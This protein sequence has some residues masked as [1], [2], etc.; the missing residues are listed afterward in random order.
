MAG[1][2]QAA[3]LLE[4]RRHGEASF[5]CGFYR[6]DWRTQS[7]PFWVKHHWHEELEI[8]HFAQGQFQVEV[9]MERFEVAGEGFCFLNSGDL[10]SIR[11]PA[12]YVEQ[13]VVFSP[14]LLCFSCGDEAQRQ[15]IQP[16]LRSDVTLPVFVP[17][18]HPVFQQLSDAFRALDHAFAGGVMPSAPAQLRIKAALLTILAALQD[19]GLLT[20]SRPSVDR[21]VEEW[22]RVLSFIHENYQSKIYVSQLARLMNM[23]EQYF[24]R[25]FKRAMGHPPVA[26]LNAYRLQQAQRLLRQT[27]LPVSEVALACGF[28]NLGH[29]MAEFKKATAMTPL[30]MRKSRESLNQ[31]FPVHTGGFTMQRKWWHGKVAYQIYPKSFYD[32][33]G[34]GIGDVPG[35]IQKLDELKALGV[36]ILWLSPIYCSPL[37]DQGY[38]IS[39][40]FSID[41]RFG[42]MDDFRRLLAEAKARDMHILMDLVVNH[43][44]DEH[45]WFQK[46]C[47]D[48]FGK[49]G[50]YFYIQKC[51]DGKLPCNWRAYFG[52][53]V[54]DKLPGHDDLYYF[55]SFH[56]KQPDL[57]WENP[58]LR[59]E[60]CKMVNWWLDQGLSGFRIDAIINIKKR[61]PFHDDPVDR[62]D[63]LSG[64]NHMLSEVQ[65]IGQFLGQLRDEAFA[66]HDAFTVGEVFDVR[67]GDLP[68]FIG[69]NG[70]FS[71]MFDFAPAI[72]GASRLGWYA[73]TPVTPDDY[74]DATFA[75]QKKVAG[76]GFLSN[77]LENHDEPRGVSRYLPDACRSEQGKKAL[78]TASLMLRGLPFLYQGQELGMENLPFSSIDEVD[79]ISTRD[80]YQ[81]ALDAGLTPEQALRA[82]AVMGRD[83]ARCPYPWSDAPNAGFTTGTPWLRVHP[84]YPTCNL[85]SQKEDPD[86]L[87]N[88]YR[89]LIA[90]RKDPSY[91]DTLFY[92]QLIPTFEE[93]EGLMAYWRKDEKKTLLVAVNFLPQPQAI[94]LTGM[95]KVLRTNGKSVKI[96]DGAL[97]LDGLQAVVLEI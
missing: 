38:D 61:L 34:D 33:N 50:R 22:K 36:D 64:L 46:A 65:G 29:F 89:S 1:S 41:P 70:Y 73:R 16:L 42:T 91:Q 5:P 62:A 66:P 72:C 15:I 79:D 18:S 43:C 95:K 47:R 60:I 51:E 35:I 58:E 80:E 53:S 69:E 24:C 74:R 32:T 78:A 7:T 90:L 39:D 56:K 12:R 8:I 2:A 57:N 49:Y 45:I 9:N 84:N 11:C 77:I 27:D 71:T 93:Q 85:A 48:P 96:E 30:Q 25:S 31:S 63:G 44:S 23:N 40:Y 81:V 86:S 3:A 52:G 67:D 59:A 10:H 88:Y 76:F 14:K 4:Q 83:N 54:W 13:A 82:V 21:R 55:H 97:K 28:G 92:G 75:S 20:F 94:P 37:A 68:D 19:G 87:Y 17:A 26:Y 6:A